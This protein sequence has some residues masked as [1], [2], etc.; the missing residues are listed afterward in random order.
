[1]GTGGLG[2]R[3]VALFPI[4]L[5]AECRARNITICYRGIWQERSMLFGFSIPATAAGI[6]GSLAIWWSN[7]ALVRLG[8]YAELAI[9]A[10]VNNMRLWSSFFPLSSRESPCHS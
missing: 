5:A 4:S 2:V 9:F 7:A 6:I 3:G 10:A 1:M 8:S